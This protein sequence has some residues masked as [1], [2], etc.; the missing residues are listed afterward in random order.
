MGLVDGA[1][2][3][4]GEEVEDA[5]DVPVRVVPVAAGDL[6]ERGE[7]VVG[8][9]GAVAQGQ[10][11][12]HAGDVDGDGAGRGVRPVDD[13]GEP[14]ERPQRVVG[15]VVAVDE[16]DGRLGGGALGDLEGALPQAGA[17]RVDGRDPYVEPVVRHVRRHG[18]RAVQR[19]HRQQG[20]GQLDEVLG[21]VVGRGARRVAL[22]PGDEQGGDVAVGARGVGGDERRGGD[23][24]AGEQGQ[25]GDLALGENSVS[26]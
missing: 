19:V 7:E 4:L 16:P 10:A 21:Q 13:A 3:V 25:R 12:A 20:G 23:L 14:A 24:A 5:A 8:D 26:P 22:E 6:V 9:A 1:V 2:V 11:A 17:Q 15:V 18:G